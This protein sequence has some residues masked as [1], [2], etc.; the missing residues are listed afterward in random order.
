M[1]VVYLG[2]LLISLGCLSLLDYR[3]RLFFWWQPRR[4]AL[5]LL[6]GLAL[7]LVWDALGIGLGI[8]LRGDSPFL[9]GIDLAPHFPVEEI[10][11]L[12]L[13]CYC[14]MLAFGAVRRLSDRRR[15]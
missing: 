3:Y 8:F 5:T 10:F 4:A 7:F 12:T 6:A 15:S 1:G 9:T 11:F 13:L 14:A 2:G